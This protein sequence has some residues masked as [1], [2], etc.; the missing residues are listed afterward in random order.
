MIDIDKFKGVNDT[1]G[2]H[3]G[4]IILQ[5]F[6][7]IIKEE[8]GIS[9]TVGRYGGEEFVILLPN[10]SKLQAYEYCRATAS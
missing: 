8:I 5:E 4:N 10:Y 3:S 9:G 2:H 6:A 1:Y 7:K